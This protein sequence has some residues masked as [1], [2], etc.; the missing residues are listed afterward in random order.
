MFYIKKNYRQPWKISPAMSFYQP[1]FFTSKLVIS[2]DLTAS[3]NVY[4]MLGWIRANHFTDKYLPAKKYPLLQKKNLI[5][6]D[7][8]PNLPTQQVI[9]NFSPSK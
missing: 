1:S 3:V 2:L 9:I 5:L 8:F 6:G 4:T 7:F